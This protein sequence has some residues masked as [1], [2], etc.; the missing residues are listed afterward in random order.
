MLFYGTGF[1]NFLHVT[2]TQDGSVEEM[3]NQNT[4][5]PIQIAKKEAEKGRQRTPVPGF[6]WPK[7]I[8]FVGA[9][10]GFLVPFFLGAFFA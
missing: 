6:N 10:L 9:C 1:S 5:R 3:G 2:H 4:C 8:L 7:S